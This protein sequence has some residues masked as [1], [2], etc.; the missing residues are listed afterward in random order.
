MESDRQEEDWRQRDQLVSQMGKNENG[1]GQCKYRQ[2]EGS[3]RYSGHVIV[4]RW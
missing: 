3:E 1:A 4:S 2:V